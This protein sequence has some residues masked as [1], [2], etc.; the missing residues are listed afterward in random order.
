MS[1]EFLAIFPNSH[2]YDTWQTF[3]RV[4]ARGI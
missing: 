2:S 1:K 4:I 3:V